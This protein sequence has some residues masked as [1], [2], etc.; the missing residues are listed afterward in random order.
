MTSNNLIT[1]GV[2]TNNLWI[3]YEIDLWTIPKLIISD[4]IHL[5]YRPKIIIPPRSY[6][7]PY[8][9]EAVGF[10]GERP[11]AMRTDCVSM[12]ECESR[13]IVPQFIMREFLLPEELMRIQ[14]HAQA[15]PTKTPLEIINECLPNVG[16]CIW[17]YRYLIHRS[18]LQSG[19]GL[20]PTP[21]EILQHHGN[22]FDTDGEYDSSAMLTYGQSFSGL[23]EPVLRMDVNDYFFNPYIIFYKK[24]DSA[25]ALV[26]KLTVL[27]NDARF[28][29]HNHENDNSSR[30][31]TNQSD[32]E[33]ISEQQFDI[34]CKDM[35]KSEENCQRSS[36]HPDD[37]LFV[38]TVGGWAESNAIV[39]KAKNTD[40]TM[41]N[42][43]ASLKRLY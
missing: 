7:K 28:T 43:K 8:Y 17:C 27:K 1:M 39:Y 35:Q 38:I 33:E 42:S 6:F 3:Y 19:A 40:T 5:I 41:E 29:T 24:R 4:D 34:I 13:N 26:N 25:P 21:I 14:D 11:C 22:L 31:H 15:N 37:D 23:V 2:D 12:R 18:C 16:F 30:R 20:V 10:L 9:H 32:D 36:N